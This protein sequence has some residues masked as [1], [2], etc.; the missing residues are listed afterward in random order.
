MYTKWE[1]QSVCLFFAFCGDCF[2]LLLLGFE[3][4]SD[5]GLTS[6]FL[7]YQVVSC[8]K[9]TQA[10]VI[11]TPNKKFV[12]K[13]RSGSDT[14]IG[15]RRC[16][17]DKH[18]LAD[19]LSAHLGSI[20]SCP[21]PSAFYAVF[22]GHGGSDAADYLN[23]NVMRILFEDADF[24]LTSDIDDAFLKKVKE[25]YRKAFL[26]ADRELA[27]DCSASTACLWNHSTDCPSTWQASASSKCWRL[28]CCSL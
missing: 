20:Y 9:R 4:N 13:I 25:S 14:A 28:S 15:P 16:N 21:M 7:G 17:E 18:I 6:L 10:T 8:S 1:I 27:D 19:D 3:I 24:P 12:P 5:M 2:M 26:L 11:E 22:D 23:N